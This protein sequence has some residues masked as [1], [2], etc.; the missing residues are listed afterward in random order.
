M[1][2]DFWYVHSLP[3]CANLWRFMGSW[4]LRMAWSVF[5]DVITKLLQIINQVCSSLSLINLFRLVVLNT[6]DVG[7][8]E[9]FCLIGY[10]MLRLHICEADHSAAG[11]Q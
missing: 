11:Y 9:S 10:V 1:R 6:D 3:F 8:L 4:C 2:A 7:F 5:E